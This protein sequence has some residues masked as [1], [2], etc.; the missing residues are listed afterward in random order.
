[1][2]TKSENAIQYF[3]IGFNCSQ[4]VLATFGQ[5]YEVPE[6]ACLRLACAFGGGMARRQMTCGAVTGAL[7]VLG[8]KFGRARNDDIS[9]KT[10]T[11]EKANDFIKEF[12]KRNGSVSCRELLHGLDMNDPEEQKVI[13]E[14]ELFQTVCVKYVRDAVEIMQGI[15]GRD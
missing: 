4:A 11:Y 12:I 15:T 1:M 10:E 8:L 13:E 3:R 7:M 5:E 6:D 14:L 2:T 9:K